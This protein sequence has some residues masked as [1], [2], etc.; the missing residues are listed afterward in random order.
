MLRVTP[1]IAIIPARNEAP[2]IGP[3]IA[4]L[5]ALPLDL[6]VLVVDDGSSD[7][8]S[9]VA[10]SFGAVVLR[11]PIPLGYGAAL[12]T[13]YRYALIRGYI[14][15]VQLDGDGQHDPVHVQSLLEALAASGADVAIGSRTLGGTLLSSPVRGLG[16][17]WLRQLGRILGAVDSTD[18]T[19]GLRALGP[20]AIRAFARDVIAEDFPELE[21]LLMMRREHLKL[22]EVPAHAKPRLSGTSMHSGLRPL[23]YA[24]KVALTGTFAAIRDRRRIASR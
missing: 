8:T 3:V 1:V 5:A 16:T 19:S 7:S 10:R 14:R 11:H 20:R 9:A 2:R 15:C 18:P 23:Y 6:D 13:G 4:G 22:V 24:Y 12:H 21:L 17:K